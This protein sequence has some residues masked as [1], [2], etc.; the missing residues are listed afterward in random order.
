[1]EIYYYTTLSVVSPLLVQCDA[2]LND[3]GEFQ[4]SSGAGLGITELSEGGVLAIIVLGIFGVALLAI[5][6]C[7]SWSMAMTCFELRARR[8]KS[9]KSFEEP[10]HNV[11]HEGHYFLTS[12]LFHH[13][14]ASEGRVNSTESVV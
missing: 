13:R 7:A 3:A 8:T 11:I 9:G 4:S 6:C 5:I 12:N 2:T 14:L 10:Q 1:M